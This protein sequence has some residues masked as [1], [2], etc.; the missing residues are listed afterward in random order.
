MY[1]N[2]EGVFS[3]A[4]NLPSHP[5]LQT[6][7]QSLLLVNPEEFTGNLLITHS[8]DVHHIL[9]SGRWYIVLYF[10][11]VICLDVTIKN[12]CD[13]LAQYIQYIELSMS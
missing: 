7:Y 2:K 8:E 11:T 10:V 1:K 4:F 3:D 13:P 9:W 12:S 6:R 5:T